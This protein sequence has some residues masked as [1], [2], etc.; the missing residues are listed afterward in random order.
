MGD[1]VTIWWIIAGTLVLLE[2]LSGSF[3]LLM[4]A[5]GAVLG[6]LSA[7]AGF[8]QT[9]QWLVAALC[10]SAFVFVCYLLRR[11]L[12]GSNRAVGNRDVNLDIGATLRVDA[13][14]DD[15]SARVQY[16]GAQWTVML[17]P[18]QAPA[19]GVHRVVEVVGSRLL[20]E[21]I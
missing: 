8:T 1:D 7:H 5:L 16:R 19:P 6:A 18:G 13:W 12:L 20:V 9:T 15:G 14:Q 3:Y 11:R 17:R 21:K 2:L 10:S 4:L